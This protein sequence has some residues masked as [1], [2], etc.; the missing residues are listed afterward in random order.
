MPTYDQNDDKF[1]DEPVVA[2]KQTIWT[3]F[4]QQFYDGSESDEDE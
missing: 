1:Y 3:P 2:A 4:R